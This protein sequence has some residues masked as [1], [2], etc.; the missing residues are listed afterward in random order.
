[1]Q[2]RPADLTDAVVAMAVSGGWKLPSTTA[3]YEPVGFGSHHWAIEDGA[4]VRWFASVDVLDEGDPDASFDRLA[5]ALDLAGAARDAGLSFVVAPARPPDGAVLRR[6]LGRYALALYP[7]VSGRAGSFNDAL[8]PVDAAELT[9]LLCS[10][11]AVP[12]AR[13]AEAGL[14]RGV[15]T[16]TLPGRSRLEEALAELADADLWPGP[17]GERLRPLLGKYAD[18]ADRVLREHDRLVTAAGSQADRLVLTHGEPHPGNLIRTT[19]GLV[20]VDW[21]TALLGP[22]ERDV[23]LLD[24]RTGGRASADYAARSGRPLR[25]ALL[26]RYHLAWSL[27]DLAEYVALL[28]FTPDQT[29]DTAWSWD[30]LISTLDD[31]AASR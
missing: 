9:G 29:A 13:N 20:L 12:H 17:Y 23:W 15:E 30:A 19:S 26:A 28:R 27:A 11:H 7:Y 8:T 5:D 2:S 4:G 1:M 22:P 6:L 31:L 3:A 18:D 25:P 16:F 10:L 24:A 21:D 14:G